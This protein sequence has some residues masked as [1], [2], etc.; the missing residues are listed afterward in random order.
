MPYATAT[1]LL[2]RFDAEEIAQ[3]A[4]RGV[5]RVVTAAMLATLAAGGDMSAYTQAERDATT[6]A[7]AVVNQAL[8][9]AD[10]TINGYL[11]GRY[12]VPLA[13]PSKMINRVACEIARFFLYDDGATEA[14]QK[15]YDA[16][17]QFLRDVSKGVLALGV[18]DAGGKPTTHDAAQIDASGP[19]FR[20]DRSTGFI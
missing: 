20:R 18:T 11:E 5:P 14:V 3:R 9:D 2:S 12:P 1:D 17:M 6:A 13:A 10:D 15:R 19:V 8:A 4:D 16:A 7:L